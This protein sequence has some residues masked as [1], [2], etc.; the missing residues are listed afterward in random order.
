MKICVL[1]F[2]IIRNNISGI[3]TTISELRKAAELS[4]T[5]LS[6][7]GSF[8]LLENVVN[9]RSKEHNFKVENRGLNDIGC[10]YYIFLIRVKTLLARIWS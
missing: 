8:N 7:Y 3:R 10:D 6:V 5:Q 4:E 2:G 1:V 9:A